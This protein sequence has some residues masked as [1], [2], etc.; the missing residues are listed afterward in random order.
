MPVA[1]VT[2]V[3]TDRIPGQQSP[4]Q[5]GEGN[6]T[7]PQKKVSM[8]R[9]KCPGIAARLC[10]RQELTQPFK[11]IL[12]IAIIP[13]D[14]SAFNAPDDMVKNSRSVKAS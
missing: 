7:C 13:E 11:K 9:K 2:A 4:H 1:L 6:F 8:I 5:S 10:S 12:T 3:E 14:L